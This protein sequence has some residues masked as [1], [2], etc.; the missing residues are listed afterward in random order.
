MQRAEQFV[1]LRR[2]P[3]EGYSI[4]FLIT[5]KHLEMMWK[6]KLID[7]IIEFMETVDKEISE[8][9]INISAR[10]RHVARQFLTEFVKN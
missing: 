3:V 6:H 2:K 1:I 7:F 9:K 4:S 5:H 8:M 10:A